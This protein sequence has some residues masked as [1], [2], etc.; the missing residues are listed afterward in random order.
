LEQINEEDPGSVGVN[1]FSDWTKDELDKYR[2]KYKKKK[3]GMKPKKRPH[4]HPVVE[5]TSYDILPTNNTPKSFNW[6]NYVK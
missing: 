6:V 4:N 2:G 5:K 1:K 3:P